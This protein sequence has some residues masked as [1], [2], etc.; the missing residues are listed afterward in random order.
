LLKRAGRPLAI[1]EVTVR[2]RARLVDLDDP[3]TLT[4][5]GC[6]PSEVAHPDRRVTQALARR[7]HASGAPGL[8]W[9]SRFRGDWASRIIFLDRVAA[10]QFSWG[11]PRVLSA[12]DADVRLAADELGLRAE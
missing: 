3:A 5:F 8:A 1:V 9:W 6:K 4:R 2:L 10:R 11:V 7:I 12:T